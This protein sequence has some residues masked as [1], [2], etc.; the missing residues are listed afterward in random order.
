M[1]GH[2]IIDVGDLISNWKSIEKDFQKKKHKKD[3]SFE[4]KVKALADE[5]YY[6]DYMVRKEGMYELIKK[7]GIFNPRKM[8]YAEPILKGYNALKPLVG[9]T[10]ISEGTVRSY[11][12]KL[13]RELKIPASELGIEL[14]KKEVVGLL[15]LAKDVKKSSSK[16][17]SLNEKR[18]KGKISEEDFEF[19]LKEFNEI[20]T[21]INIVL[22]EQIGELE[23]MLKKKEEFMPKIIQND[24]N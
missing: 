14:T 24:T 21:G 4:K 7:H 8:E 10:N 6:V 5:D 22:D 2:V 19:M 11:C 13:F 20:M 9:F 16:I 12:K 23:F 17:K 15:S 18:A 1:L 3:K